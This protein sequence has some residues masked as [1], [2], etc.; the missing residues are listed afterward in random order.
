MGITLYS[1]VVVHVFTEP[2]LFF[3]LIGI[4][5]Y[6]IAF[7][8]LNFTEIAEITGKIRSRLAHHLSR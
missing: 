2:T 8:A 1:L 5:A 4:A 7:T 3:M 6:A